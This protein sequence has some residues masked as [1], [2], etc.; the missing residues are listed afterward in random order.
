MVEA[1]VMV[2]TQIDKPEAKT[3]QRVVYEKQ[4]AIID[5]HVSD[6]IIA[7]NKLDA[8]STYVV[9]LAHGTMETEID[10]IEVSPR[11]GEF[12]RAMEGLDAQEDIVVEKIEAIKK[13]VQQ[14]KAT[15]SALYILKPQLKEQARK[16][17][18]VVDKQIQTYTEWGSA[19]G[20]IIA[21]IGTAA[22]AGAT[23]PVTVA[24]AVIGTATHA[25]IVYGAS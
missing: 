13:E 12:E 3:T 19:A 8:E 15:L 11:F 20:N 5:E 21:V 1:M 16:N 18:L 25:Y 7:H 24:T 17:M 9:V 4:L 23:A 10:G 6:S 2:L 22:I 14:S